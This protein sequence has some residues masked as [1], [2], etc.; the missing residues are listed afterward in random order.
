VKNPDGARIGLKN[1]LIVPFF[2][3]SL[4][5][6][7]S[8][9][10]SDRK[11]TIGERS[12]Q[13]LISPTPLRS[14]VLRRRIRKT[15]ISIAGQRISPKT[16]SRPSREIVALKYCPILSYKKSG[17]LRR[18][19]MRNPHEKPLTILHFRITILQ[20]PEKQGIRAICGLLL[21]TLFPSA[22]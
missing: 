13:N 18:R 21:P 11:P 3:N 17:I 15:A 12:W 14:V 9:E 19:N 6:G 1:L 8:E 16:Y 4:D 22:E 7:V 5:S 2:L 10:R 20:N